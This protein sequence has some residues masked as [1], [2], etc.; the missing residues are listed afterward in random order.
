MDVPKEQRHFRKNWNGLAT[1]CSPVYH[2]CFDEGTLVGAQIPFFGPCAK[3]WEK[4]R[5]RMHPVQ[6]L[7]FKARSSIFLGALHVATKRQR[8][9]I[10]KT[11][12]RRSF[13][14]FGGTNEDIL[15]GS[16]LLISTA[17]MSMSCW[18]MLEWCGRRKK[19]ALQFLTVKKWL[20]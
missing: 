11:R 9:G 13:R 2:V 6:T 14:P 4:G 17:Q 7:P 8:L 10:P 18:M 3:G 20:Q 1:R 19:L 16:G 12:T 5:E 15:R